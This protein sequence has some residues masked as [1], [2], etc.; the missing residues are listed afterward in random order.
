MVW[1]WVLIGAVAAGP[2]W[3]AAVIWTA[4]RLRRRNMPKKSDSSSAHEG[5]VELN[6]LV[7]GLAHEIKNP[8][9]TINVNLRLLSEDLERPGDENDRRRSLRRLQSVR[10]ETR[11]VE[12]ILED[13]LRF[14]GKHE[15]TLCVTDLRTLVDELADFFA[16]QAQAAHVIMRTALPDS[17]VPCNVDVN[18]IKQAILNLMINAIEA[19]ADAGELFVKVSAEPERA[20]VEV[21]DTGPGMDPETMQ[22]IFTPY[23]STKKGGSGLGLP[24]CRR[25]IREH[26]GRLEVT[27]EPGKG[28]RFVIS[29]PLAQQ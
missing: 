21:I 14:A 23:F 8:L 15:L 7:S 5:F 12:R 4:T 17:P 3:V 11:R 27:S 19:I 26:G 24:T 9:S 25:I 6:R 20:I 16:P 18:L 28:T 22:N 29:L 10:E 1:L 13:F 2:V